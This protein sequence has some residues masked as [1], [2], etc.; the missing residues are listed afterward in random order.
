CYSEICKQYHSTNRSLIK[1]KLKTRTILTAGVSN[2]AILEH[3]K[4]ANNKQL[5]KLEYANKNNNSLLEITSL[6][7][8]INQ[9]KSLLSI[10]INEK[11][12]GKMQKFQQIWRRRIKRN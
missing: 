1:K 10:G 11:F 2:M 7:G 12:P 9:S 5:A 4:H 8:T 3:K 6:Q